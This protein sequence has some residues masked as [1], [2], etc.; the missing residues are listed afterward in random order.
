[1]GNLNFVD[2]FS[3]NVGGDTALTGLRCPPTYVQ[4][5]N[6]CVFA[7]SFTTTTN[8]QAAIGTKIIKFL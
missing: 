3:V 5:I 7:P 8:F 2:K 1:M 4:F 6:K